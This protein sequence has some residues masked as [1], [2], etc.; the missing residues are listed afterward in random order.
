LLSEELV[1]PALFAP[2]LV[3]E[4]EV[5]DVIALTGGVSVLALGVYSAVEVRAFEPADVE[6]IEEDEE[7]AAPVAPAD[8]LV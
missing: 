8:E 7:A 4:E 5:L 3:E 1:E 2:L 6:P